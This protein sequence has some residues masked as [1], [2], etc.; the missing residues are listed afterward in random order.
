LLTTSALLVGAIRNNNVTQAMGHNNDAI[1]ALLSGPATASPST[2]LD[3]SNN[4]AT[5]P[6]NAGGGGFR[7]IFV[8]TPDTGTSP[9][10]DVTVNN[11]TVSTQGLAADGIALQ[12]RRGNGDFHVQGNS[13]TSQQGDGIFIRQVVADVGNPSSFDLERG[14]SAS[15]DPTTII[16]QNNPAVTGGATHTI[17]VSG[18]INPVANGAVTTVPLLASAGG[19]VSSLSSGGDYDLSPALLNAVVLAAIARWEA[20]GLSADKVAFLHGLSFSVDHMDGAALGVATPGSVKIDSDAGSYGWF[21]DQTPE[22]DTEFG[23]ATSA[24]QRMTDP[25]Q[26]PA[27]HM[28]LLTAVMHEMG[29][30]LGLAD[31]YAGGDR[32]DLMF[33]FLTTGERRLPD[34]GDAAV[35][36]TM[37]SNIALRPLVVGTAGNDTVNA[38]HGGNILV[39]LAG[40][41]T[42][43]FANVEAHTSAPPPLTHVADYHFTEGD[44]FDFSALTASFHGSNMN[45]AFVVRA[46]EDASGTFATLQVNTANF[47]W[48]TKLGPTWTDVAQIDGAHA[49]DDVSVLIDNG[50]IHRAQ[51]HVD[52]LV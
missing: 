29:H 46:V 34:A 39:G 15:N 52:L 21:V 10:F 18:T 25:N 51:I 5:T 20:A 33:G 24:T 47:S 30:Q 12:A 36:S 41:D 27:G 32:D 2:V 26:A 9:T 16:L 23:H 4:T 13:S 8:D 35:A 3:I 43:V 17:G 38:G 1:K 11:N 40:A 22:S 49:G 48:G 28:D 44:V 7:G 31:S 45:D 19:V 37:A 14:V 50:T 42:F 6:L